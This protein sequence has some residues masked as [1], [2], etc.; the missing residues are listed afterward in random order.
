MNW[1]V[2]ERKGQERSSWLWQVR[3][4]G[5]GRN[6]GKLSE[7]EECVVSVNVRVGGQIKV[8]NTFVTHRK[9]GAQVEQEGRC[10]KCSSEASRQYISNVKLPLP[11]C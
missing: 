7:Y 11:Q 8:T 5:S 2:R 9:G 3:R 4:V 10:S 6:A 1:F